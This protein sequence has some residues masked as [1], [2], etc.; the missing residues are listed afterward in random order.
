MAKKAPRS[1]SLNHDNP[2]SADGLAMI[3]DM[4]HTKICFERLALGEF[5][6]DESVRRALY[7]SGLISFRRCVGGDARSMR[8]DAPGGGVTGKIGKEGLGKILSSAYTKIANQMYSLA[9]EH[10]AHRHY[11]P[12]LRTVTA[13]IGPDGKNRLLGVWN[14]PPINQLDQFAKVA[15]ELYLY[16]CRRTTEAMPPDA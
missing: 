11:L 8:R 12:G 2:E 13:D 7:Q 10:V 4:C 16:L 1:S 9:D 5:E 3:D 15:N 6:A 14:L